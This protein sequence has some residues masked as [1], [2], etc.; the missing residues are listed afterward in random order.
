[1]TACDL[2]MMLVAYLLGSAQND[3]L[4]EARHCAMQASFKRSI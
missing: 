4:G 3:A 2:D 1:V